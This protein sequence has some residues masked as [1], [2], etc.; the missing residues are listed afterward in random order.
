[1][2]S[3]CITVFLQWKDRHV[4][5]M[6]ST[7]V[8]TANKYMLAKRRKKGKDIRLHISIKKLQ[9]EDDYNAGMLGVDK[10]DQLI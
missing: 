2:G 6:M 9:L 1:M 8:H 7:V 10:S 3:K 5:H 4:V